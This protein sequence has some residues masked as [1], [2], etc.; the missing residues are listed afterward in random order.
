MFGRRLGVE[1]FSL[2][3]FDLVEDDELPDSKLIAMFWY[4]GTGR[5]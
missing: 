1:L 5:L 4:L 2:N 3:V